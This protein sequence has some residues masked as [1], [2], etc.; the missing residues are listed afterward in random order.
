MTNLYVGNLSFDTK[1][2]E[3]RSAFAE[4]G[5]VESV[6]LITDRD[7]GKSRGF[8][9]VQMATSDDADAAIKALD[10][11]PLGD[12][13]IRV[14]IAKDRASGGGG[15]NGGGRGGRGGGRGGRGGGARY[16]GGG[17]RGGDRE[18]YGERRGYRG[19]DGGRDRGDRDGDY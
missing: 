2:E 7:S 17:H 8:A 6:R 16:G 5:T 12:R 10:D 3:L 15:G 13:N 11:T 18:P 4:H 1:E 9:F 14:N 19:R